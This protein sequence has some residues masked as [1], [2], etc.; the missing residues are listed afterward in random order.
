MTPQIMRV[1]REDTSLFLSFNMTELPDLGYVNQQLL[2]RLKYEHDQ[3]LVAL[4]KTLYLQLGESRIDICFKT[5]DDGNIDSESWNALCTILEEY[6]YTLKQAVTII[7]WMDDV[8]K[9]DDQ[10]HV[11]V[12]ILECASC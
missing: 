6:S 11:Y 3:D 5:N 12:E 10:D 2:S 4:L 9:M 8:I 1:Y 7:Q